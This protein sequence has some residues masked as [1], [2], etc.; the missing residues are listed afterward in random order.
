MRNLISNL[1]MCLLYFALGWMIGGQG[2]DCNDS[3]EAKTLA[4]GRVRTVYL[5]EKNLATIHVNPNGTIISFPVHPT[6]V[7]IGKQKI[8]DVDYIENDI[9]IA[10]LATE[11][12]S[13]VFVYLLGKRYGFTLQV[14]PS[15]GDDV[16]IVRDTDRNA[17]EVLV[18]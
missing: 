4:G 18:Q 12:A 9:A 14:A 15:G 13:N 17:S 16:V 6:K 11:G 1:G 8:F 7:I 3:A 10:P 2:V 5:D